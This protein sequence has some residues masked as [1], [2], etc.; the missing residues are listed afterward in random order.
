MCRERRPRPRLGPPCPLRCGKTCNNWRGS[1]HTALLQL[2][3]A[4]QPSP[5]RQ[6]PRLRNSC[7]QPRPLITQYIALHL[8]QL[9]LHVCT[10]YGQTLPSSSSSCVC[11][12]LH[13]QSPCRRSAARGAC[14]RHLEHAVGEGQPHDAASTSDSA[15]LREEQ[16]VMAT[17]GPR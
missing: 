15:C 13:C 6:Y 2:L 17:L 10:Q 11:V 9:H 5:H 16:L 7:R 8:L 4:M 12:G 14:P 1:S 3:H